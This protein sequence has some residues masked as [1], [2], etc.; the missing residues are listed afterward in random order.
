MSTRELIAGESVSAGPP[1]PRRYVVA[2]IA[3]MVIAAAVGCGR[4]DMGRVSGVVTY[5]GKPVADAVVSFRPKNRPMAFGR[6]DAAGRFTLNTFSKGDGAVKGANRVRIEPW[7]PGPDSVPE[8]GQDPRPWKDP[9]RDDIPKKF[10]QE[11]TSGLEVEVIAGKR[12]EFSFE[13]AE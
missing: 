13:L 5:Q 2:G 3:I 11:E 12:N 10:R 4:A 7:S 1:S 9:I 8:P 6:T